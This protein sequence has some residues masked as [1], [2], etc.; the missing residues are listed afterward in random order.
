VGGDAIVRPAD[1][2][3]RWTRTVGGRVVGVAVPATVT[4]VFATGTRS[5]PASGP[6]GGV[7][8]APVAGSVRSTGTGVS[9]I[10]SDTGG[11]VG[12]DVTVAAVSVS[13]GPPAG[14][15]RDHRNTNMP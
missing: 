12:V 4:A 14:G 13:A 11:G 10:R 15:R 6:A 7:T 9:A 5:S 1:V 8:V 3:D 2:T